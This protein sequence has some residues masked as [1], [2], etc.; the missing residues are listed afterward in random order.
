M[1]Y[2]TIQNLM[3]RDKGGYRCYHVW[4]PGWNRTLEYLAIIVRFEPDH[5]PNYL[6]IQVITLQAMGSS[7]LS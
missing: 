7:F 1:T 5:N 3:P 2:E 4:T 6:G